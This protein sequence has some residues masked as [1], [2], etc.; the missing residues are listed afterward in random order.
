MCGKSAWLCDISVCSVFYDV[1]MCTCVPQH[2]CER[3]GIVCRSCFLLLP[4]GPRDWSGQAYQWILLPMEAPSWFFGVFKLTDSGSLAT[5]I[6]YLNPSKPGTLSPV[7]SS[8]LGMCW[9]LCVNR[10]VAI[11][12][13]WSPLGKLPVESVLSEEKVGGISAPKHQVHSAPSNHPS[14]RQW[15]VLIC[16]HSPLANV[17][18]YQ[19]TSYFSNRVKCLALSSKNWSLDD[20]F[21][22][23]LKISFP[24]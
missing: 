17:L 15:R 24:T 6:V 2:V 14:R 3:Q 8:M 4:R 22:S 7:Y 10:Y 23:H 11:Q 12:T 21:F 1:C 5:L 19:S 16:Y 20:L 9:R 18:L 13:V